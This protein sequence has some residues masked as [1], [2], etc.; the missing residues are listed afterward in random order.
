MSYMPAIVEKL[1]RLDAILSRFDEK[2]II[3]PLEDN[4]Q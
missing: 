3:N 2:E 4:A 1:D